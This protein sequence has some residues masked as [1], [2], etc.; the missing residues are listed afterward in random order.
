MIALIER[1]RCWFVPMRPVTPFMMMPT[2]CGVMWKRA[3]GHSAAGDDVPA[4]GPMYPESSFRLFGAL[5]GGARRQGR[6][7]THA[8]GRQGSV[9]FLPSMGHVASGAANLH[10]V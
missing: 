4:R 9:E 2:L 10:Q 3:A 5:R 6:S 8:G 1:S 7:G